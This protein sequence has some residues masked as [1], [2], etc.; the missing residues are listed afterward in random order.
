[1]SAAPRSLPDDALFVVP[2]AEFTATRNALVRRLRESGQDDVARAMAR[3]R[4][5]HVALWAANQALRADRRAVDR[6][7]DSVARLKAAQSETPATMRP[8]LGQQRAALDELL[9]TAR[10]SL[11]AVGARVTPDL[12]ARISATLLGAAVD[13]ASRNDVERGR[14]T[15][16]RQAPGF[17]AFDTGPARRRSRAADEAPPPPARTSRNERTTRPKAADR[18]VIALDAARR[19]REARA[20]LDAERAARREEA[21]ALRAD[22]EQRREAA[23]A[24]AR[25]IETA[26]AELHRLTT[27]HAEARREANAAERAARRGAKRARGR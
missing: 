6:L 20:A 10:T 1:M 5:P 25:E 7:L 21:A 17:D 14:L 26:R 9:A 11:D 23:A 2:P 3:R 19:A 4:K 12:L 27:R 13:P 18:K 16:E 22:G 8:A 15:E 24:I